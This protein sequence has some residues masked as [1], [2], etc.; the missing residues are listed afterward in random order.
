MYVS[1][2]LVPDKETNLHTI[3]MESF[4]IL[5]PKAYAFSFDDNGLLG[6]RAS[7]CLYSGMIVTYKTKN[8]L[9]SP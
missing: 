5:T 2:N 9:D 8:N 6:C 1:L 3:M 4:R 7:G